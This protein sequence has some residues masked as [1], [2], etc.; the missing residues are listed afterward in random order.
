LLVLATALS[1]RHSRLQ[2]STSKR[3]RRCGDFENVEVEIRKG[4]FIYLDPPYHPT[5]DASFTKYTKENFTEA[6]QV[7]LR[8]FVVRL[9][10]KG[11]F[12]MLSNSKTKFITDLYASDRF[13][14]HTVMA[15]RTVN[16]KP[17]QTRVSRT[18]IPSTMA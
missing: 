11:A 9:H 7:R 18:F 15:P 13:F 2:P 8:D 12:V 16:Y 4:D 1:K 17:L 6:D 10:K 3:P 5:S 14:P